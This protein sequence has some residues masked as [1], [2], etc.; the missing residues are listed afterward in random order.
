M[1]F[2]IREYLTPDGISYFGK[3]FEG[4]NAIAA[5]KVRVAIARME[6]GNFSNTKSVGSGVWEVK[7]DYGP[8]YRVYYGK[9]G[10]KIVILLAGGTKKSQQKDIQKAHDLWAEFK[11]RKKGH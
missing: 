3:W 4:L 5:A 6:M 8:G 2:N 11:K 7:I 9:D 1:L 10:E